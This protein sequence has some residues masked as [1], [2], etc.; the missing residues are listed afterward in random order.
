MTTLAGTS[1]SVAGALRAGGLAQQEDHLFSVVVQRSF[2]ERTVFR[3][4]LEA[5]QQKQRPQMR[6]GEVGQLESFR[7]LKNQLAVAKGSIDEGEAENLVDLVDR[8][9]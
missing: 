8:F 2:R 6:I 1:N 7:F 4:R 3:H 9:F 5:C